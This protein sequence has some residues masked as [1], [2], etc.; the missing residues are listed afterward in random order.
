MVKWSSVHLG[1]AFPGDVMLPSSNTWDMD[2]TKYGKVCI[3]THWSSW[4][5]YHW[6]KFLIY[7]EPSPLCI[8][9]NIQKQAHPESTE[10]IYYIGKFI[11]HNLQ[12]IISWIIDTWLKVAFVFMFM[13]TI[14]LWLFLSLYSWLSKFN[15]KCLMTIYFYKQ[16]LTIPANAD[17]IDFASVYLWYLFI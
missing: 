15:E 12:N 1:K 5:I 6:W 17:W 14:A 10:L 3:N 7:V 4:G 9:R 2:I 16:V 8:I 11:H 13:D